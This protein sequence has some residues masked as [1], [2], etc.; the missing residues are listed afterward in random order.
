MPIELVSF[1]SDKPE[2]V[3]EDKIFRLG[4]D[5]MQQFENKI[6]DLKEGYLYRFYVDG[7]YVWL[8]LFK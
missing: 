3:G 4:C 2:E 7:Q 6:R 1:L 8:K 5:D